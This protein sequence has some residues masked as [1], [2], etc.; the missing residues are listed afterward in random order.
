V[1]L[2][3]AGAA[4][5]ELVLGD[6]SRVPV[7]GEMTIGRSPDATVQLTDPTVS[8]LHARIDAGRLQDAG[9]RYGTF[10]DG[11]RVEG[12]MPLR[13]GATIG[14][15]D[16]ELR[17][18]RRRDAYEAGRTIVVA[19]AGSA[20]AARFG[21]R[22]RVRSGYAI[23]RLDASEGSKRWVLRDLRNGTFLRLSDRD[24]RLFELVDGSRT[25]SDLIV[26]AEALFGAAG[27][28]RLARLL[29]E[30]G[31]RG[32]LDGVAGR[33]SAVYP[34]SGWRRLLRRRDR[35]FPGAGRL[36][37]WLYRR[38]GWLLFTRPVLLTVA[39]L[40][41][42]GIGVFAYLV[43]GRYGTP[44]V[45]ASKLGLGGLVFLG[46]RFAVVAVHELAHGLTMASYGRR[47][48]R[49]GLRLV[50]VFPYAFVDTSQAWFEPRRRRIAISAAGPLSDLALGGA[51]ALL[52]LAVA[53]GATRDVLF[54]LAFAAYVSA[55]FNLSPFLDRDGYHILVDWLRQPG[56]RRRAR[57]QLAGRLSGGGG[58]FDSP[59]LARYAICGL[60]WSAMAGLFEVVLTLRYAPVAFDLVGPDAVVWIVL[61]TLWLAFFVPV[62]VVVGKPLLDR[63]RGAPRPS[64]SSAPP[65]GG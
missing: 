31:E 47:V 24:A 57:E 44:F 38:G 53:P 2:P 62:L 12:S 64:P 18:E 42:T 9:S 33:R 54:Q 65:T 10:L 40:G 39:L 49:A 1:A 4:A 56:L 60:V 3:G 29:A 30:L 23:K 19:D 26:E 41:V 16:S 7:T 28:A 52:C 50:L 13:D 32:L 35:T 45:V 21:S 25:L 63:V 58:S 48:E 11:T 51:F 55:F 37:E 34:V 59:A 8:R 27:A 14:V 61:V 43:A 5:Y 15:G 20:G 46:G 36:F 6:A 22:P 17:V